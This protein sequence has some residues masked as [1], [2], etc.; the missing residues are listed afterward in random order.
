MMK[1]QEKV[2][3]QKV[4][5]AAAVSVLVMLTVMFLYFY[6]VQQ[7]TVA[8]KAYIVPNPALE[9]GLKAFKPSQLHE[10]GM[11]LEKKWFALMAKPKCYNQNDPISI[12]DVTILQNS[13]L[14]PIL[15]IKD[16]R[17]NKRID[18]VGGIRGLKELEKLV[19]SG[20]MKVA[21]SLF[22]VSVDQV[23]DVAD[24]GKIMPPKSTWFE[25]KLR[26]GLV[27]HSIY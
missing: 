17:T 4:L 11:Y 2:K 7:K 19:D 12:L 6:P 10:F 23:M 9:A 3:V 1:E 26:D 22:P 14:D 27:V 5:V 20:K 15:G 24:A 13:V 16:P 21:F 25:P 18:F 8:G